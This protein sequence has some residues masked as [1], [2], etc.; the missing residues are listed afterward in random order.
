MNAELTHAVRFAEA[1]LNGADKDSAIVLGAALSRVLAALTSPCTCR[2]DVVC[3]ACMSGATDPATATRQKLAD[4][5][6]EALAKR[7]ADEIEYRV[8][9]AVALA[10]G[11]HS[12][13][14]QVADGRASVPVILAQFEVRPRGTVT[15]AERYALALRAIA[16]GD[17]PE[18]VREF[19]RDA[20]V[21]EAQR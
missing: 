12:I 15:D 21:R 7:L 2:E 13:A 14:A 4:D 9:T 20:L 3:G 16:D 5:V 8:R 17:G 6:R 10:K 1:A 18:F 11:G 19:A